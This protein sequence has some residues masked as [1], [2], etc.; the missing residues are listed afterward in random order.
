MDEEAVD[1]HISTKPERSVYTPGDFREWQQTERLNLSP[2]FQRRGVWTTPAKSFFLDT[3]LRQMPVPPIYIR[4]IAGRSDAGF[5]REVI[6]GQQ[7]IRAVLGFMEGEYS[8]SKTLEAAW[9]GKRFS[10][11]SRALQDRIRD[12]SFNVEIFRGISDQEV[13]EIFSR[14]NTYSVRAND[15]ELRNGKYFGLFKR[16]V[17]RTARLYLDFWRKNKIFSESSIARMLEAELVSELYVAM[18]AGMQDKK[19]SLDTFYREHDE[20][21]AKEK[22]LERR[23]SSVLDEISTSFESQL[24]ELLFRR[25][26]HFYTLF[27]VIYHKM[28]GLSKASLKTERKRLRDDD[29]I[30]LWDAAVAISEAYDLVR[31]GEEPEVGANVSQYLRGS[32][33][34]QMDNIKPRQDRFVG[35]YK[36]AFQ[37]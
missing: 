27:C 5:I 7:R 37:D 6:D 22:I 16:S 20:N 23:L 3:L 11:L 19:K 33:G 30:A 36:M 4:Q 17:Y 34:G 14:L 9:S 35:L 2:K 28:Y 31:D 15:Q 13:L 29:R 1:L 8:L 18:L 21:F 10:G 24:N 32:T 26:P 25:P 12:Y